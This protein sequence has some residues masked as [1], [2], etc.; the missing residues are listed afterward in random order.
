MKLC[1]IY[2][3]LTAKTFV[4]KTN[5]TRWLCWETIVKHMKSGLHAYL[6]RPLDLL[7]MPRLRFDV[8][9]IRR[10]IAA[11]P[12]ARAT[13]GTGVIYECFSDCSSLWAVFCLGGLFSFDR[14]VRPFFL[15]FFLL[16]FLPRL[17][18]CRRLGGGFG[19]TFGVGRTVCT[20]SARRAQFFTEAFFSNTSLLKSAALPPLSG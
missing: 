7:R 20:G 9:P 8:E 18:F 10:A 15:C 19:G 14:G 11:P 1:I 6:T 13:M 4:R 17:F 12:K 5:I 16:F 3:H 2:V